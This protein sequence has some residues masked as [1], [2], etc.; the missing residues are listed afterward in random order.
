MVHYLGPG[1]LAD[2]ETLQGSLSMATQAFDYSRTPNQ[3]QTWVTGS[4]PDGDVSPFFRTLLV[5]WCL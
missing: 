4:R 3:V 2:V 5:T 1:R